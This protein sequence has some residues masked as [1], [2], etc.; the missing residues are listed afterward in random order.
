MKLL[1]HVG[2]SVAK[3]GWKALNTAETYTS[4]FADIQESINTLTDTNASTMDK[5]AAG[6]S[7]ASEA[8]PLSVGDVKEVGKAAEGLTKD[9]SKIGATGKVGEEALK[10]LGG[11][12]QKTFKTSQGIRRVDQFTKRVAHESKVGYQ[13]LT[14]GIKSQILKDAELIKKEN[15][16]DATWHLGRYARHYR[17][18]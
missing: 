11:I 12:S 1:W 5:V 18:P 4:A 16:D 8:L 3:N 13:S 2:K 17:L 6:V 9:Y 15:I 10:Q 7:L 14:K